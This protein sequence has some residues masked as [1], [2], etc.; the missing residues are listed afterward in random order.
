[1]IPE[2]SRPPC[3]SAAAW[4]S[5]IEKGKPIFK[6]NYNILQTRRGV[7][8]HIS[9]F[10]PVENNLCQTFLVIVHTH[11]QVGW[12][13]F[14]NWEKFWIESVLFASIGS[15]ALRCYLSFAA[16]GLTECYRV[17]RDGGAAQ[18]VARLPQQALLWAG[19]HCC[20]HEIP[21]QMNHVGKTVGFLRQGRLGSTSTPVCPP[22]STDRASG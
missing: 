17:M 19:K 8:N 15:W 22:L 18:L 21:P 1:M 3:Q 7:H 13:H 16:G 11:F 4:G 14:F 5:C 2:P 9:T 12:Q 20:H 6:C 10:V